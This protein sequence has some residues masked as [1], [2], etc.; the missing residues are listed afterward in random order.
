V[1]AKQVNVIRHAQK[2]TSHPKHVGV[3][4]DGTS[5]SESLTVRGWLHAGALAAVFGGRARTP[6]RFIW[7]GPILS[8][9]LGRGEARDHQRQ[10]S[11]GWQP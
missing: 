7:I 9:L 4:E 2:P 10:V 5:D 11:D 3:R 1:S 6:S 8:S